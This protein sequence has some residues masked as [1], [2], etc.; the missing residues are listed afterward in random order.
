[1]RITRSAPAKINLAL[2]VVGQRAD[3]YHL[4]DTL[5]AFAAIGDTIEAEIDERLALTVAGPFAHALG[6]D[7]TDN[8]VLRAAYLMA[9]EAVR[10]GRARP[11]ARLTLTKH[12]PVASGVG[13]GSADAAATLI[14]LNDLWQLELDA[15][16]LAAI[17][18]ALGADV[19][20]CLNGAPSRVTGIGECVAPA[21]ILPDHGLLLVNPRVPVS[22]PQVFRGLTRRDHPPLPDLPEVWSD[23]DH[24]VDWLTPTRNDLQHPAQAIAPDIAVTLAL[25]RDLPGCRLARMSGSGAT[26]FAIFGDDA[27]AGMAADVVREMRPTWWVG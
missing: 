3:G 7:G 6:G 8:L 24:F 23:V 26:C 10:R 20:M 12:L 25:M 5:V 17:G 1:M 15:A 21:P 2:H 11:G 27:A 18:L 13:G 19:P 14:A 22:T 16:Y 4:L 9:D